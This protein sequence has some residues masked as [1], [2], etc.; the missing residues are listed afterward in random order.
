M[1]H[2][3]T[4]ARR[5]CGPRE[6]ANGG[7]VCGLIARFARGTVTVR[8]L[9]PP[10]L[11]TPMILGEHDGLLELRLGTDVLAR[12]RPGDVDGL[13][14]PAAPTAAEAVEASRRYA[15]FQ[16]HPAPACF[17]CGPERAPA[18]G[19][20][21]FAGALD[22]YK[23]GPAAVAA[24]WTPDPSLDA[25]DGRVRSEFMWAALDCPGFAAAAPDMRPML[26]GELTA[27]V[28]RRAAIGERCVVVGWPIASEGRKHEAGTA[29]F[30]ADGEL[31]ARGRATWIEPRRP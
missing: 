15:G 11:D 12:A 21:I 5:F 18:D 28:D 22:P 8:L 29:V 1:Q 26:L 13:V 6:S 20:R 19:L 9:A 25:G 30:G 17:V 10:P 14:P 7:Y 3:V 4:V 16:A 24:P 23:N 31:Y 2:T 27:Q